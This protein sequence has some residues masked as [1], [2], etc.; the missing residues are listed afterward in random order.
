MSG[1]VSSIDRSVERPPGRRRARLRLGL[2][3]VLV[4][5]AFVGVL[6]RIAS[7]QDA[8]DRLSGA[9]PSALALLAAASLWNLASYWPLLILVLPGLTVRQAAISNQVST[10]VAN[11]VPAGGAWGA[12]ITVGMYRDWGFP[13]AEVARALLVSGL[14]N[15]AAK[16]LLAAIAIGLL[17]VAHD[18]RLPVGLGMVSA[19]VL[20]VGVVVGALVLRRPGPGR[21]L[22]G[23]VERTVRAVERRLGRPS[24]HRWVAAADELRRDTDALIRGRWR[25]LT[26]VT[27][28][29]HLSL[30]LVL[31]AA[32]HTTGLREVSLV[33]A[34]AV[35]SLV[36][37][38]MVVPVTPGGAGFT[39]VGLAALLAVVGAEP[40]AAVGTV[41]VFRAVTWALPIVLGAGC[42]ALWIRER[43]VAGG[44]A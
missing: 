26:V 14:W 25:L 35:F 15:V 13:R 36:R 29:S 10:A 43:R 33:E 42:W 22:I 20:V 6:P 5:I 18:D 1:A 7:Y 32:M 9:D 38:A 16:L 28:V 34:F 12:G 3:V 19:L 39:E 27:V 41:L 23:R 31:V 44:A 24:H 2:S 8:W 4:S 30:F 11:T 37:V 17:A 40:A 21:A